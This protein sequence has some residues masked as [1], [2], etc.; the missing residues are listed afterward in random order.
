MQFINIFHIILFSFFSIVSQV[1]LLVNNAGVMGEREGW[2]LCLDVNLYGVLL[3]C[4]QMFKR[5]TPSDDS[6]EAPA[7]DPQLTVINV[8]SILGLFTGHEPKGW[9]Y[10][11]SKSGVVVATR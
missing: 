5:A 8:A 4:D 2:K 9:A 6:P 1:S 10:N 11:A 3:G 7:E